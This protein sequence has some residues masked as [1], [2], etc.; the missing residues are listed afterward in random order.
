MTK[1]LSRLYSLGATSFAPE[2]YRLERKVSGGGFG[3]MANKRSQL[4]GW[5]RIMPVRRGT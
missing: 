5:L 1:F 2:R 4:L 3:K